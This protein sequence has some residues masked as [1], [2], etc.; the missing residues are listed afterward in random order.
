MS[1][2][3]EKVYQHQQ[4]DLGMTKEEWII[5]RDTVLT[6]DRF[7]CQRCDKRFKR[8]ELSAHH[9]MPRDEGGSSE[10]SNLITL[11]NPCHDFVEINQLKTRADIIGSYESPAKSSKDETEPI[12]EPKRPDWHTWV[13]GGSRRPSKVAVTSR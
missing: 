11:C 8:G 9:I 10:M 1:H 5:L 6:R 3:Q 4:D 13:Y 2:W 12:T 7:Y